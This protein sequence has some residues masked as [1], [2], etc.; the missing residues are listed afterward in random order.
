LWRTEV[1]E[2]S[3]IADSVP[4]FKKERKEKLGKEKLGKEK[5]GKEKLGSYRP[6]SI[7]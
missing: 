7:I 3:K 6:I 5:L 1:S 4:A 2:S